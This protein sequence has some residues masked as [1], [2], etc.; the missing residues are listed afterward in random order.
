MRTLAQLAKYLLKVPSSDS[1]ESAGTALDLQVLEDRILYSAV[2]MPVDM[3]S[4]APDSSGAEAPDPFDVPAL[5]S[6]VMHWSDGSDSEQAESEQTNGKRTASAERSVESNPEN[7]EGHVGGE[8]GDGEA[9]DGEASDE[10]NR[11]VAAGSGTV[12]V[13]TS[14]GSSVTINE[15]D[16]LV[17]TEESLIGGGNSIANGTD[18][19]FDL[20]SDEGKVYLRGVE[21]SGSN[22]FSVD[23]LRSGQVLYLPNLDFVGN[24]RFDFRFTDQSSNEQIARVDVTISGQPDDTFANVGDLLAPIQNTVGLGTTEDVTSTAS[25]EDGGYVTALAKDS[26]GGTQIA[27]QR[28]DQNGDLV[29]AETIVNGTTNVG[30]DPDVIGLGDGGYMVV[31]QEGSDT[32]ADL[33]GMRFNSVGEAVNIDGSAN[34]GLTPTQLATTADRESQ[35]SLTSMSDGGFAMVYSSQSRLAAVGLSDIVIQVFS[36]DG[37]TAGPQILDPGTVLNT[38]GD[39]KIVELE[40]N[41][42]GVVWVDASTIRALVLDPLGNVI[43]PAT[44][45]A[46]TTDSQSVRITKKGGDE[47]AITWEGGS[48]VSDRGIYGAYLRP[49]GNFTESPTLL[50]LLDQLQLVSHDITANADGTILMVVQQTSET[51][52]KLVFDDELDVVS[53]VQVTLL[54]SNQEQIEPD[55]AL[56]KNGN[57]VVSYADDQGAN[58]I[59]RVMHLESAVKGSHATSIL[60]PIDYG[61]LAESAGETITGVFLRGL[62]VGTSIN[63]DSGDTLVVTAIGDANITGRD[64]T[65]LTVVLPASSTAIEEASLIVNSSQDGN[66]STTR[67]DFRILQTGVTPPPVTQTIGGSVVNDLN[68]DGST[69]GDAGLSSVDVYLYER[70][71]DASSG[72]YSLTQFSTTQTTA[73]GRYEFTNV[74][75]GN[76]YL[77]VVDSKSISGGASIADT[78]WA[79]QTYS[80]AGG[81]VSSSTLDFDV[82][83]TDG[84]L[85]GGKDAGV[86]DRFDAS[87]ATIADIQHANFFVANE[88][89]TR[90]SN[91]DFGFNF[92]IVNHLSDGDE[93]GS[94]SDGRSSQGSLRQFL[95]NANALAGGNEMVFVPDVGSATSSGA[96]R[97]WEIEIN[98]LLPEILDDGT[99]VDGN[100][101]KTS[102]SGLVRNDLNL[103]TIDGFYS[104]TVGVDPAIGGFG[105]SSQM[106]V[107]GVES[108]DLQIWT[109]RSDLEYGLKVSATSSNIDVTDV[110]IRNLS[111]YGF[112]QEPS[113]TGNSRETAN[114][115]IDGSGV[116]SDGTQRNVSDL[117][118]SGNAFGVGASGSRVSGAESDAHNLLIVSASGTGTSF[119]SR[120]KII[121]NLFVDAGMSGVRLQDVPGSPSDGSSRWILQNNEISTNGKRQD[122]FSNGIALARGVSDVEIVGNLIANNSSFGIDLY[123]AGDDHVIQFNDVVGNGKLSAAGGGMAIQGNGTSILG[124]RILDNENAGIL[125]SVDSSTSTTG[126]LVSRNQFG[127]NSGIAIDQIS[128][129]NPAG[130]DAGDGIT[131]ND[132]GNNASVANE[133]FDSPTINAAR[134]NGDQIVLTFADSFPFVDSDADGVLDAGSLR[135]IE[136]YIAE[137]DSTADVLSGTSDFYGEGTEWLATIAASDFS[138]VNGFWTVAVDKPVAGWAGRANSLTASTKL[139]AIAIDGNGNTSEFGRNQ[140]IN[141]A[142]VARPNN[143]LTTTEETPVTFNA[144]DFVFDDVNNDALDSIVIES[145]PNAA[146]GVLRLSGNPVTPGDRIAASDISSLTFEPALNYFG[147]VELDYR[148]SDGVEDSGI[149]TFRIDVTPVNDVPTIDPTQRY[150]INEHEQAD[151]DVLGL[152]NASDADGDPLT[153]EIVGGRD[154]DLF[155]IVDNR[156]VSNGPISLDGGADEIFQVRVAA[157]DGIAMSDAGRIVLVVRNVN[158]SPTIDGTQSYEIDEYEHADIDV[159]G[160]ANALD[161]DGDSLT[162]D[163]VGGRDR[164]LFS[165]VENRLVSNGPFSLNDGS[166]EI[167]LVSVAASDGTAISE[168]SRVSLNVRNVNDLPVYVDSVAE[169]VVLTNPGAESV[170]LDAVDKD[171]DPL[172]YEIV[173]SPHASLFQINPQNGR[174]QFIDSSGLADGDSFDLNLSVSDGV[175]NAVLRSLRITVNLPGEAVVPSGEAD[176]PGSGPPIEN[177]TES[178][179]NSDR[180]EPASDLPVTPGVLIPTGTPVIERD[181]GG[182]GNNPGNSRGKNQFGADVFANTDVSTSD[183]ET[184]TFKNILVQ[185]SF[186]EYSAN[187]RP[188]E[189]L[190]QQ[191]SDVVRSRRV[192][193]KLD[194]NSTAISSLFWQDLDSSKK[195]YLESTLT[196][197]TLPIVAQAGLLSLGFVGY[198]SFGGVF[199]TTVATQVSA[200]T[201]LDVTALITEFDEDEESSETIHQIVDG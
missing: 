108:P 18:V 139:T 46:D 75:V 73:T 122:R 87:N 43:I 160:L 54:N 144:S 133:G 51:V 11:P 129:S 193:E 16:Y 148:V 68:L 89:L 113:A 180:V 28:F 185:D 96:T 8:V 103:G 22:R 64:L 82:T 128:Q 98:E 41:R 62:P 29:G 169:E 157:N 63:F 36:A 118:I 4:V 196:A 200:W 124:N 50:V 80:S 76:E 161:A 147:S 97:W 24:D 15:G 112:G 91:I 30:S 146:E 172:R 179:S 60:L 156:L 61:V 171:G 189:L 195:Y 174:L 104:G 136:L 37:S 47:L 79:Q 78:A 21:L 5:E 134:L 1:H 45:I 106:T 184:D 182:Q 72:T 100:A 177:Q 20:E 10:A 181:S 17:I 168:I 192:S 94:L 13:S 137:A 19:V 52:S 121:N 135:E 32:S 48:N 59:A 42:L 66:V 115:I 158:D 111:V 178:D 173:D 150:E 143:G 198:L 142:P 3:A 153:L 58:P 130:H 56:L 149:Q 99:V 116:E 140:I 35:V 164:D 85:I 151:F 86:S 67:H 201:S 152:A 71:F 49:D 107:S 74:V 105:G 167:F 34:P 109:Q 93:S 166:D 188:T 55:I 12:P 162:L 155:S 199:L 33:L 77:V 126:I 186:F 165:I 159:L 9:S 138:L 125:L 191:V 27:L 120:N 57:L 39:P 90:L 26:G 145:L 38:E 83:T 114:L 6:P 70:T 23:D 53:A 176:S 170:D 7:D 92:N 31:W 190:S 40:S 132:G 127:G 14:I 102:A 141:S 110:E 175:G 95:V 163:I 44:E 197:D 81:I 65:N 183:I 117:V 123:D 88:A 119:D 25:L 187:E 131:L 154:R 101:W 2:P 194:F 84:Y 69:V